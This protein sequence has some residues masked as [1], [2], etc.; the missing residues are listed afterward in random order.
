ME[1][2]KKVFTWLLGQSTWIKIVA[3]AIAAA[4]AAVFLFSSCSAIQQTVPTIKDNQ[5]GV[6]GVVS[7]EKT[8]SKQTRWFY[9]PENEPS[10]IDSDESY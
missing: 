10:K 9:K 5:L 2:L 3:I 1:N 6:E 4:A 7:K 8:V